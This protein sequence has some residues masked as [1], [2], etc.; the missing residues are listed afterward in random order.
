MTLGGMTRALEVLRTGPLVTVQDRGRC[1]LA[2][3]GVSRAGAADRTASARAG[4]LVGNAPGAAGLE[5]LLGGLEVATTAPLVLALSGADCPL[6]LDG[7]PVPAETALE[8]R[9]GQRLALGAARGGLRAY[10]AVRGGLA[11]PPVLG[12]RSRDTLSALGPEP[13]RVGDLLPVGPPTGPDVEERP[14]LD[15]VPVAAPAG[16][17]EVVVLRALA[18]PRQD[19]LDPASA[20]RL[21][22]QTWHV[23]PRSDRIGVGL[24]G[25][26][27]GLAAGAAELPSEPLVRGAV[28]LPPGGLPVAFL[29]D[30]PVTGG[31]PVVAVVLDADTDRLGQ[32]R[33]GQ[34][35]RLRRATAADLG[36]PPFRPDLR[37]P[38]WGW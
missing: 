35:V 20:G 5:V 9:A 7:R 31:Y 26:P 11:V 32:L 33:P 14:P 38:W 21:W 30:H 12:S 6:T 17:D 16:P 18:G 13:L 10:L 15:Q 29:A 22:E 23:S 24:E 1:G 8:L 37:C 19:R 2:H 27:L 34:P 4:R 3:L 28:Q 25:P 36:V